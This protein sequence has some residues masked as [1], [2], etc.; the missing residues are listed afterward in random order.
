V[1]DRETRVRSQYE[2][3]L[4]G[5][6]PTALYV[7]WYLRHGGARYAEDLF[8]AMGSSTFARVLDVGCATGFYL[9]SAF[10]HGHGRGMLAGLDL[11]PIMLKEAS[12]RL[13]PARRAGVDIRLVQGSARTLPFPDEAFDA[14]V[15]NG[16]AKYLDDEMLSDFLGEA[17]RVLAPGGRLAVA[18]FGRP[19]P[20]QAAITP[21]SRLGIPVDHLRTEQQ[22]C[23]A[24]TKQG[25][26]HVRG[27]PLKRLKRIPLTYEG[28]VGMKPTKP[29]EKTGR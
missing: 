2:D 12:A 18:D 27:V 23:D 17:W 15:C 1:T 4:S 8:E 24:L 3:W 16:V 19:V 21:P 29:A 5:L 14:L 20:L 25:F 28:A 11:S 13:E 22:F 6:S 7:R 10:Q 26:A 9:L